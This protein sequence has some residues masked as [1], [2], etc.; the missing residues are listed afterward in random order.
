M[1]QDIVDFLV[2]LRDSHQGDEFDS[3]QSSGRLL[4]SLLDPG[5]KKGIFLRGLLKSRGCLH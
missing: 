2:R 3:L 4:H 5:V 1:R